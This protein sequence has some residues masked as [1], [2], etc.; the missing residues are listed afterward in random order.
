MTV[1]ELE[2]LVSNVIFFM[3]DMSFEEVDIIRKRAEAFLKNAEKLI[4]E[5]QWDLAIFNLE[6]YCQLFLKHKLLHLKGS[7]PKTHSL[8]VMI[9]TLA[10]A[11]PKLLELVE[12]EKHLHYIARL[13]EAYIVARYL[14]YTFEEK[15]VK[16]IHRFVIEV[17]KPLVEKL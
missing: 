1:F 2:I 15:E 9:R 5:G 7:Y 13:E 12:N 10:Q 6:Q 14:P 11:E 4:V 3:N 17:F 16:D 8:R